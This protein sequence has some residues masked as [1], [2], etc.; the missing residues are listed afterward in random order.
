M[1]ST[2]IP[3]ALGVSPTTLAAWR[4]GALGEREANR[5]RAH[6]SECAACRAQLTTADRLDAA[7]RA[8]SVPAPDERLWRGVRDGIAHPQRPRDANRSGRRTTRR[9]IFSGIAAVAAIALITVGFARVFQLRQAA[10]H[11]HGAH[12]TTTT[13]PNT[14]VTAV[15]EQTQAVAGTPL[16]WQGA[17]LPPGVASDPTQGVL[18]MA[19]AATDGNTAYACYTPG[20]SNPPI[21]VWVTHDRATMWA[22]AGQLPS[23]DSVSECALQVD[24]GD[25][26]RIVANISGQ[27]MTTFATINVVYLSDDGGATWRLVPNTTL[28]GELITVG[29]TSF[30]LQWSSSLIT[31]VGHIVMS[32]DG[33]QSWRPLDLALQAHGSVTSFWLAP[34]GATVLATV[35]ARSVQ[36]LTTLWQ[37]T[38]IGKHWSQVLA[39]KAGLANQFTVQARKVGQPWHIC[40]YGELQASSN[41][42]GFALFCTRDGGATWQTLP[43]L[44]LTGLCSSCAGGKET[45]ELFWLTI[46]NDGSLLG[47]SLVGPT[48]AGVIQQVIGSGL[49]RLTP[50]ASQWVSLGFMLGSA[51]LYV[52]APGAGVLWGL[53]AGVYGSMTLAANIGGNQN[54]P[55]QIGTTTYP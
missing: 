52:G 2:T 48:K 24:Q 39:P 28:L 6:I 21:Q 19:I 47:S 35:R 12:A 18:T 9:A 50:G 22:L 10:I 25:A 41:A 45:S 3:C 37:T 23:I 5:L 26:Q 32:Q 15:P 30:A 46:A 1:S 8:Q 31:G 43:G 11:P 38:D 53:V 4:D 33:G 54:S 14:N 27:N 49:Y 36:A 40:E 29:D 13:T 7:L 16:T 44:N 20:I 55:R 42:P 34:D 17:T 51:F